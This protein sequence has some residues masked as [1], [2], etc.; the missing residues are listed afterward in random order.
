MI[1]QQG[2]RRRGLSIERKLPLLVVVSL[3]VVLGSALAIAYYEVTR[4]ARLAASEVRRRVAQELAASAETSTQQRARLLRQLGT[5]TVMRRILAGGPADTAALRD[6]YRRRIP[7]A[8]STVA[9]RFWSEDG[10]V[11]PVRLELASSALSE[12]EPV[13]PVRD[14]SAHFGRLYANAGRVFFWIT[15]P[16]IHNGRRL[17]WI[18]EQRRVATSAEEEQRIKRVIGPAITVYFRNDS[19]SFWSNLRGSPVSPPV[20]ERQ[21]H[22][23]TTHLR[24]DDSATGRRFV[25]EAHIRGTPWTIALEEPVTATTAGARATLLRF[26]AFSLLLLMVIGFVMWVIS[27][28]LTRPLVELTTATETIAQGDFRSSVSDS[29]VARTDEIGRLAWSFNRMAAEVSTSQAALEQRVTEARASAAEN[30]RLFQEAYEARR[31][32]EA[33]NLSKSEF[34]ATM[35]HEIRTPVNAI[36]GYT[37]LMEMGI[38]GAVTGEQRA[39]LERISTSGKHLLGLIDDVLD[40][41]RIDAG[42]LTVGTTTALAPTAVEAAL[43][44]IRAQAAAK[45]ITLKN[46]CEGAREVAYVGDE[47]RV[48]QVLLNLLSN[49]VKFTPPRGRV[50]LTCGRALSLPAEAETNGRSGPW[51]Y[52]AV[53]D[54]GIGISAAMLQRIYQPFVQVE[55]GYTRPHSGTGLGLTI[56]RRLARLMGGDLTVESDEGRGSCFTLW[57]PAA[58]DAAAGPVPFPAKPMAEAAPLA[59]LEMGSTEHFGHLGHALLEQLP[60]ILN[61]FSESLHREAATIPAVER[62]TELQLRDHHQTWLADVAQALVVLAAEVDDPSELLRDGTEIQRTIA[63]RHGVQRHRLGWTAEAVSREFHLLRVALEEALVDTLA[64]LP[65][66]PSAFARSV[67]SGLVLQAEQMSLGSFH[68][69]ERIAPAVAPHI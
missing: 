56:G 24:P 55:S 8:D 32:A 60:T 48:Q 46:A 67:L 47:Q 41:A 4:S 54:N 64:A 31:L 16:V 59:A 28:R 52:I 39:Q 45:G 35:S 51:T 11:L 6:V 43:G 62:L 38:A 3:A 61:R 5:D 22:G 36:I 40:L 1:E 9:L 15:S 27:R 37:Q 13:I 23:L 10:R 44:L 20:G 58:K 49:A 12:S 68:H 53:E 29:H 26:S 18:A 25:E 30:A 63:E 57:L 17:G 7:G 33:A 14:D 69:C 66:K 2:K 42:K 21:E 34:L 65:P 50:I 19:G